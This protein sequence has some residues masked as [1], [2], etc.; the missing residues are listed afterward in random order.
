MTASLRLIPLSPSQC[1]Q[2]LEQKEQKEQKKGLSSIGNVMPLTEESEYH[3][4]LHRNTVILKLCSRDSCTDI[5]ELDD[6]DNYEPERV[7][8]SK[9]YQD[10]SISATVPLGRN[11][12]TEIKWTAVSRATLD[13]SLCLANRNGKEKDVLCLELDHEGG[14][15]EVV[16]LSTPP[17]GDMKVAA[18]SDKA[19][20]GEGKD[21]NNVAKASSRQGVNGGSND[22]KETAVALYLMRREPEKHCVHINGIK[23]DKKVGSSFPLE[24]KSIIS[25]YG[26]T[27]MAY[28][29]HIF[30]HDDDAK[31]FTT[32][33]NR[34][35]KRRKKTPP[36]KKEETPVKKKGGIEE[37]EPSLTERQKIRQSAQMEMVG[38]S[39]CAM[40]M[41]ILVKTEFANPCAHPFCGGCSK[42]LSTASASTASPARNTRHTPYIG[43]C[44][45]CRCDIEGWMSGRSFDA[46]IWAIALQG[47]FEASDAKAY[48]E[49][50]EKLRL[51]GGKNLDPPTEGQRASIMNEAEEG[52]G[53][54]AKAVAMNGLVVSHVPSAPISFKTL[55]PLKNVESMIT[56]A[57]NGKTHANGS[58]KRS[59]K[60]GDDDDVI[61]ID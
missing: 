52:G 59:T 37:E 2:L 61:C 48:L 14:E 55:S 15:A 28:Q 3:H 40:C 32:T 47:C 4:A 42:S 54:N 1:E 5:V 23:V 50:R 17:D 56:N 26:P 38:E 41:D 11:A 9:K 49:S 46:H 19:I 36:S 10:G 18:S 8:Y 43:K 60:S 21:S 58:M 20:N 57:N 45:T 35:P 25:L 53:G 44:P 7:I 33:C 24:N 51:D 13:V 34:S 31:A 6:D 16:D 30:Q 29:V 27:G 39:T 12:D 22:K